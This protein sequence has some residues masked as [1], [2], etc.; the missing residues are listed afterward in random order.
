MGVVGLGGEIE[1]KKSKKERETHGHRQL[2][3]DCQGECGRGRRRRVEED[4]W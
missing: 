1:K 3:G 4:K 2:C